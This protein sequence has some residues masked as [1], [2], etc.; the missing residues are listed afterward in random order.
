MSLS[1]PYLLYKIWPTFHGPLSYPAWFQILS[2][3]SFQ[4]LLMRV[5]PGAR[6]SGPTTPK[7]NTPVYTANGLQCYAL[8]LVALV[9]VDSLG[10]YDISLVYD[11]FG[12]VLSCLNVFALGFCLF[13]YVK[14]AVKP[15]TDDAGTNGSFI[16][17]YYWGVELY[18]EVLGW[19]VKM[20]TNCRSGMM[21]WSVGEICFA[22]VR[23]AE[24][25]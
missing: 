3:M 23:E 15:S 18:P 6:F 9:A 17:D 16:M 5:V 13:L 4:L 10:L 24:G 21:F 19:D 14:G 7:G 20:F 25:G 2:F 11:N 1:D 8:T 12:H 22:K